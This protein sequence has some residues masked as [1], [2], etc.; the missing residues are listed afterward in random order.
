VRKSHPK[1]SSRSTSITGCLPVP[2][3]SPV[4]DPKPTSPDTPL[5]SEEPEH[6]EREHH[7]Q[8]LLDGPCALPRRTR[9]RKNL[10]GET[11]R[12]RLPL[13]PCPTA[14]RTLTSSSCS[15]RRLL[16]R[17][18]CRLSDCCHGGRRIGRSHCCR[19][20]GS[21]KAF[22]C[23]S[24]AHFFSGPAKHASVSRWSTNRCCRS[25]FGRR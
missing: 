3:S 24:V 22:V 19:R 4:F 5:A 1:K 2:L 8:L 7:Q 17:G 12:H 14:L 16:I 13:R 9:P 10:S 23:R 21:C 18:H 25:K 20:R 11:F 15:R 6:I